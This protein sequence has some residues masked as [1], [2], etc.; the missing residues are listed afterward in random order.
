VYADQITVREARE[1][2]AHAHNGGATL[3]DIIR[4]AEQSCG[5]KAVAL[6]L[7]QGDMS[8]LRS[9]MQSQ[10]GMKSGADSM[11]SDSSR[12]DETNTRATGSDETGRTS[13]PANRAN[14]TRRAATD[15]SSTA[16]TARRDEANRSSTE[17]RSAQN[18]SHGDAQ[19][20]YRVTCLVDNTKLRDVI[21]D[22]DGG[23]LG[24][25]LAGADAGTRYGDSRSDNRYSSDAY[26]DNRYQDNRYSSDIYDNRSRTQESRYGRQY[27]ERRYDAGYDE[28]RVYY[29]DDAYSTR[30]PSYITPNAWPPRP[31]D[32]YYDDFRNSEDNARYGTGQ[33]SPESEYADRRY[34]D[35]RRY[36]RP[37][38]RYDNRMTSTNPA[39]HMATRLLNLPVRDPEGTDLG[40]V[41]DVVVDLADGRV[42]YVVL[43]TNGFL[44]IGSEL[45]AI[46][47]E[48]IRA[49]WDRCVTAIHKYEIDNRKGFDRQDWP[50][51]ANAY[52]SSRADYT[53]SSE[54]KQW[55]KVSDL[56][57][58]DV[59][60]T[61]EEDLGDVDDAVLDPGL[62][63]LSYILVNPAER[64][65]NV[66]VPAD[67]FAAFDGDKLT[68][69]MPKSDF[70]A[71]RT[72]RENQMPDWSNERW[73]RN[74]R[75]SFN[76]AT[77]TSGQP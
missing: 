59:R 77:M 32:R 74:Q 73:D 49:E 12:M 18:R 54:V 31:G 68:L 71:H 36:V 21:V 52:W 37:D 57:D 17:D 51:H 28:D 26:R 14:P 10:P 15:R 35:S 70:M 50:V 22:C 33:Y 6:T 38:D 4:A 5:G 47:P 60:N 20:A 72:F 65:G 30:N 39:H 58:A 40:R 67:A 41:D 55:A 66:P 45:F 75:A 44:G 23:I 61:R 19:Y 42:L 25:Q 9:R 16:D 46:P 63:R 13:D 8:Q 64:D 76:V 1:V 27:G 62:T 29:D 11:R 69:R 53:A 34:D 2:V 56:V 24:T 3:Q 7:F 43:E 48:E